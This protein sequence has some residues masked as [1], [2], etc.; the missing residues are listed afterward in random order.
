MSGVLIT[1]TGPSLSGK[2]TLGDMLRESGFAVKATTTTTRPPREGEVNGEHYH[3][4]SK[5]DFKEKINNNEMIEFVEFDGNF[6]GLSKHEVEQKLTEG[7]VLA[8]VLEPV[9]AN[10]VKSYSIEKGFPCLQV[11]VC[12][13]EDV[14]RQRFDDRFK[15]DKLADPV[16]YE[17]RWNSM[18]TVELSWRNQMKSADLFFE[19]F[20][21]SNESSVCDKVVEVATDL[22]QSSGL[23]KKFKF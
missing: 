7:S 16:V 6:Y 20:D 9:G 11:F 15:N 2:S 8:V 13:P 19:Q 5:A 21:K 4:I 23:S 14:L 3:F 12:N 18:K 10:A 1:I 17:S 22:K